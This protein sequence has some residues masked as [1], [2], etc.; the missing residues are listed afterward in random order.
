DRA[1][2]ASA[3]EPVAQAGGEPH[4]ASRSLDRHG[5]I[6]A[7]AAEYQAEP[8]VHQG[9][10]VHAMGAAHATGEL[11]TPA[12]VQERHPGRRHHDAQSLGRLAPVDLVVAEPEVQLPAV[13]GL[14]QRGA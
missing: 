2:A 1:A 14:E 10:R 13:L 11:P 5:G 3:S 6:Y 7:E 9:G 4:A 8:G 12:D